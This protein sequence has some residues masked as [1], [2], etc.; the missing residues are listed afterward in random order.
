[1]NN[2]HQDD[3]SL[4]MYMPGDALV[5]HAH[6]FMAS[7]LCKEPYANKANAFNDLA[8]KATIVPL[9]PSVCL[10]PLKSRTTSDT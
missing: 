1:M 9:N 6:V 7:A 2:K 3:E 4:E 5:E 8:S 10:S